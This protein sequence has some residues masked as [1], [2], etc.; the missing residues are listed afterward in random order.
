MEKLNISKK[1]ILLF[2]GEDIPKLVDKFT[3]EGTNVIGI[4]GNDLF[5]EYCLRTSSKLKVLKKI[6]WN[7]E[8]YLFKKPTLC[9]L[10]P[11]N[12][13]LNDLSKRIRIGINR[14]YTCIS[15]EYLKQWKKEGQ[16]IQCRYF[17]GETEQTVKQGLTDLCIEIVCTGSSLQKNGLQI[18]DKVFESDLV[19][20][21]DGK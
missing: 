12:K 6:E 7:N 16:K 15:E 17:S 21:G 4:T 5:T 14:K 13:T 1:D 2:R 20:V 8:A 18:Y 9:L 3:Q 19:I 10:G 11:E